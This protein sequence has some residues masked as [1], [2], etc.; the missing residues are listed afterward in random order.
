M[1][2]YTYITNTFN[3]KL[4]HAADLTTFECGKKSTDLSQISLQNFWLIISG[5]VWSDIFV[6]WL[7][8]MTN[9]SYIINNKINNSIYIK[10]NSIVK[11]TIVN[12]FL[13]HI[14]SY[15]FLYFLL[16]IVLICKFLRVKASPKWLNVNVILIYFIM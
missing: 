16:S 1:T 14:L 6:Q 12:K 8:N 4:V 10:N 9:N 2:F 5:I 13:S 15:I 11:Y 3:H 7:I